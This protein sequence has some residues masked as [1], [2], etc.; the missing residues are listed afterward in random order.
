MPA[1]P[2]SPR[3]LKLGV[4]SRE[5]DLTPICSTP[6]SPAEEQEVSGF[7]A[8]VRARDAQNPAVQAILKK[9]GSKWQS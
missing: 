6:L 7:L 5:L 1:P 9:Y 8:A 4:E 2:T 3:R